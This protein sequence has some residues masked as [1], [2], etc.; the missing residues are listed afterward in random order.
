MEKAITYQAN[1]EELLREYHEFA[2]FYGREVV[3]DKESGKKGFRAPYGKTKAWFL[4]KVPNYTK[5]D[6]TQSAKGND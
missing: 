3:I 6:F 5:I 1:R 4:E 2:K